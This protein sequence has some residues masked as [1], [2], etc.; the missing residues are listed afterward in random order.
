MLIVVEVPVYLVWLAQVGYLTGQELPRGDIARWAPPV[1]VPPVAVL[2]CVMAGWTWWLSVGSRTCSPLREKWIVASLVFVAVSS[3]FCGVASVDDPSMSVGLLSAIVTGLGM[4]G[5]FFIPAAASRQLPDVIRRRSSTTRDEA[6]RSSRPAPARLPGTRA[7][8][9]VARG[10]FPN[11]GIPAHRDHHRGQHEWWHVQVEDQGVQ[12]TGRG[13]SRQELIRRRRRSGFVGRRSEQAAF[14]EAL[15]QVPEESTQF[16]FHIHGPGGV[17]KSTLARQ[18]ANAAREAGA[19]TAYVDESVA[20]PIEAMESVSTQLA[21]Q[22]A[23]SK[24]FDK[25]LAAYRQRRH[26]AD[27][28]LA[29]TERA[30]DS[31][32]ATPPPSPSSMVVSQ[33]GLAGLGLLPGVGAFTGAVD[34]S[35]V[36]AGADRLKAMLSAR[37]RSHEDVRLVL[38]PL[39]VLTPA[40]LHGLAD[41]AR[42]RPW[43]VLIFDTYER[44]GPVL[45]TWLRDVTFSDRYGE[46]PAN[47]ML[48]LA[49]QSRLAPQCWGDWLDFI[50]DLPLEVF[51]EDEVRY[52]LAAKG[53]TDERVI[54]LVL[55][56][57]K[58][59]PVLVS[60]LAE[61]RPTD[62]AAV[63]DPSGTAV[64]RFLRWETDPARRA[65]ALACALPLELDEDVCRTAVDDEETAGELF[66]WLRSLPFVRDDAGRCLYHDVVRNAMLR[67]QRNQSPERWREQHA[68]LASAYQQQRQ[69]IEGRAGSDGAGWNDERWRSARVHETY[70]RLCADARAALPEALGEL[71]SAYHHDLTTLR[72]WVDIVARAGED[73]EATMITEAGQRLQAAL[74][75]PDPPIAALTILL[76]QAILRSPSRALAHALRG[77]QHRKA[78][79]YELAI[80]DYDRAI[81]LGVEG[82]LAHFGR[83]LTRLAV[84]QY[85]DALADFT[86]AVEANPAD[87]TNLAQRAWT[88]NLLGENE[89]AARDY[90]RALALEP[91]DIFARTMRGAWRRRL[92]QHDEAIADFDRA[93]AIDPSYVYALTSRGLAYQALHRYD[94]AIAD[95]DQ[96][97]AIEPDSAWIL[98]VR[99][100]THRLEG[101]NAAALG[102]LTRA[103]E[104]SPDDGFALTLRGLVYRVT[105]Q[106][107]AALAD[108]THAVEL[109]PDGGWAHYERAVALHALHD[110]A[111]EQALARAIEILEATRASSEAPSHVVPVLGNLFLAHCLMPHRDKASYYLTAF[112]DV[113][114]APGRLSE[115]LIAMNT[116]VDIRPDMDEFLT[117]FRRLLAEA[118]T[119]AAGRYAAAPPR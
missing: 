69:G 52:L 60:M 30:A 119:D 41:A 111:C 68:R 84:H 101:R 92:G 46:L 66:D 98:S 11:V 65:A 81:E 71:V 29:E 5:L 1:L 61:A 114:P 88:H 44:T 103:L 14:Q 107:D 50:T 13:P 47:V 25:V 49:G 80:A 100:K 106:Y 116:L 16:F 55:K 57:S 2:F 12:V 59:L 99:A 10:Q 110:P 82:D 15:R 19:I 23:S 56:L 53:V 112:L 83:G 117:P 42:S 36:A 32:A 20:D 33:L 40:F 38:S 48:L 72:H 28:G 104:V 78:E 22:G 63:G 45:D 8:G 37:L 43:V 96:A 113:Q 35:H 9:H 105:G 97:L 90:D 7:A 54:E 70:H 62:P 26:D 93:F 95:F 21:A 94:E 58:G 109:D 4:I 86:R 118:L 31:P 89:E 102:D 77:R 85:R 51:T 24:E 34:A 74:D 3:V 17:G 27:S 108:L 73:T 67:L 79:R 91:D 75:E 87:P 18:L 64:E 39:Q 6:A 115:L 76:S